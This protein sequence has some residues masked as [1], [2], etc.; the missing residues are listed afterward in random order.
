MPKFPS[1]PIAEI[2]AVATPEGGMVHRVTRQR[3]PNRLYTPRLERSYTVSAADGGVESVT[4]H[5]PGRLTPLGRKTAVGTTAVGAT[6]A[7]AYH[8]RKKV[9]KS[10]TTSVWG[11]EHGDEVSKH[12]LGRHGEGHHHD[13]GQ[14]RTL[15]YEKKKYKGY[16]NSASNT[17]YYKAAEKAKKKGDDTWYE[18]GE[19]VH[20]LFGGDSYKYRQQAG[21]KPSEKAGLKARQEW[22]ESKA[23]R[24]A[25]RKQGRAKANWNPRWGERNGYKR[26]DV[27][28]SYEQHEEVMKAFKFRALGGKKPTAAPAQSDGVKRGLAM[29]NN[30]KVGNVSRVSSQKFAAPT[31]RL[32]VQKAFKPILGGKGVGLSPATRNLRSAQTNGAQ[33]GARAQFGGRSQ[34]QFGAAA[35]RINAR[36]GQARSQFGGRASAQFGGVTNRLSGNRAAGAA[37][38]NQTQG[39]SAVPRGAGANAN[40]A[41]NALRQPAGRHRGPGLL[42]QNRKKIGIGA[43]VAGAG[44]VGYGV[45]KHADGPTKGRQAAGGLLP[46]AHGLAAG[47]KGRKLRA[48]GN[49]VGGVSV[50]TVAG[51]VVNGA[52]RGRLLYAI[53]AGAAAG[54]VMGTRRA[55]RMGH[56]KSQ[57]S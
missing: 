43:G 23:G 46:G 54:G 14:H 1:R 20:G 6:S 27:R 26:K 12:Y 8:K 53:P 11:V 42:Q 22:E 38:F 21:Y 10:M 41:A 34:G 52:A 28:K 29:V 32:G 44:G 56:Y 50:G 3:K 4:T 57:G 49:E 39:G 5:M 15:K 16:A 18:V 33:A 35:A 55:H 45:A 19:T 37:R 7:Y 47:K 48:A 2:Q 17:A 36:G 51:S 25:R 40:A 30:P 13:R 24:S 31:P 9:K